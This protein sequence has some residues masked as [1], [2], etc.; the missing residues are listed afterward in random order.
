MTMRERW[1]LVWPWVRGLV[2]VRDL[3]ILTGL[4]SML[5]GFFLIYRPAAWLFAG[6]FCLWLSFRRPSRPSV[7]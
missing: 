7:P 1:N 5:R 4:A 3:V 2:D 6:M